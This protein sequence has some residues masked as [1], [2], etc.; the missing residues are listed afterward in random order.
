MKENPAHVHLIWPKGEVPVEEFH[1]S[2]QEDCLHPED[3]INCDAHAEALK[4]FDEET[5]P[6]AVPVPTAAETAAKNVLGDKTNEVDNNQDGGD[7]GGN[8]S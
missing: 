4:A 2:L 3:E 1:G 6:P 8:N 7:D 5:A